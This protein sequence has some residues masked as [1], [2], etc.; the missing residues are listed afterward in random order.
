MKIDQADIE[1]LRKGKP[2]LNEELLAAMTLGRHLWL[3]RVRDYYLDNYIANG[4]SKVKVLIGSKGTGKTH[5]IRCVQLDAKNLGYEIVYISARNYKLNNL[6]DLYCAIAQKIDTDKL[7]KGLC[8]CVAEKLGYGKDKYDGTD[9]FLSMLIDIGIPREQVIQ[10]VKA[11]AAEI[12]RNVDFGPS[13]RT[14]AYQI[15]KY[16][17]IGGNES[18]IK[19]ALKW[20]SGQALQR[21]EK[22]ALLLFERLQKNNAR[23]WLN[24]LIRLLHLAGIT[25]LVVAIDNLEVVTERIP[26]TKKFRYTTNAI[27]DIYEIF[28]QLIDDAELLNNFLLLLAGNQEL[29]EDETRGFKSYDALWMRL[30]TGFIQNIKFNPFADMINVDYHLIA[31]GK[32][33]PDRIHA[34]LRQI[35]KD[36]KIKMK[37][38]GF[39]NPQSSSDLQS[40]VMEAAMMIPDVELNTE[41]K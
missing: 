32:D 13:F 6:I 9:N 27:K 1:Y 3:D 36:M 2:P 22:Q 15:V 8:C 30:Q 19:L 17:M 18:D 39:S 7:I 31:Q 40:R 41:S 16:H 25:G 23:Y 35:F 37:Y 29:T 38:R 5:L 24:S 33:F 11:S 20:V 4:G 28:R 14:F 34:K 10:D 21:K 26:D 12:F